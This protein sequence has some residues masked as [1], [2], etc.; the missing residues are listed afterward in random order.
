ME[1]TEIWIYR[2]SIVDGI[3]VRYNF[4][5]GSQETMPHQGGGGPAGVIHI[6]VPRG[7]KV[8]GI[9]GGIANGAFGGLT[10]SHLRILVLDAEQQI[11]IYGPFGSWLSNNP[12][13]FAVY[14]NIKSFF[15]YYRQHQN[16]QY[17]SGLG[18]FY[19][20]WGVCGSPCAVKTEADE[21][22]G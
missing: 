3:Q 8:I 2:G 7:G 4:S 22:S 12:G 11:R 9:T 1:I 16:K 17:I 18:V 13:T 14:G 19:E 21:G 6:A 15:G 20:P 5:D 10:I